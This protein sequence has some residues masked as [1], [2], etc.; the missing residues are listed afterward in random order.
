M[1]WSSI[2]VTAQ[3]LAVTRAVAVEEQRVHLPEAILQC[4]WLRRCGRG[5]GDA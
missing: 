4:C 1:L 5:D 3:A 2:G